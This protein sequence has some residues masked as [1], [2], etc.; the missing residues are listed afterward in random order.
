MLPFMRYGTAAR[1]TDDN[2]KRRMRFEC[3]TTKA[4]NAHSEYVIIIAFRRQKMVMRTS[5]QFCVDTYVVS[6]LSYYYNFARKLSE[7]YYY[8]Y[9]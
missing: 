7:N 8:Y 1:T 2:I 4:T 5:P 6:L 9:Y 3:W